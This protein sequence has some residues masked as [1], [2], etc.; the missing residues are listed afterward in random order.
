MRNVAVLASAIAV[1]FTVPAQ[2]Q[3]IRTAEAQDQVF[4]WMKVYDFKAATAP[5]TVDHR[6]YSIAQLSV[7][8]TFANWI[9][10]S[11]LPVGGLGDV[12]RFVSEK[13]TASNQDTRS[14]PQSY[15]AIARIY[16]DLKYGAAR[17]VE[18]ASNSH[19]LWSVSANDVYG[20]PATELSKNPKIVEPV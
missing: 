13:L 18:L 20:E 15:G 8:N 11:Y 2:A 12:T 3:P 1:L 6:V 19:I 10:Q 9:Q 5:M 16:T 17:K 14:L 4:G 7:A